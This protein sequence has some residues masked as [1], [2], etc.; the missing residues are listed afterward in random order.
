MTQ[1]F[2][3][4]Q[5]NW[6]WET[7]TGMTTGRSFHQILPFSSTE[8]AVIGGEDGSGGCAN[9]IELYDVTSDSWSTHATT[10]VEF[11]R[12]NFGALEQDGKFY[13]IGGEE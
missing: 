6:Q 5:G 11:A 1:T 4:E 3:E 7:I 8:A 9:T 13:I 10:S 2:Q 12:K